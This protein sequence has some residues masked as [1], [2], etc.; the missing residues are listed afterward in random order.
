[1]RKIIGSLILVFCLSSCNS[2][3]RF[4]VMSDMSVDA[5]A[6][7]QVITC[8]DNETNE[9]LVYRSTFN[10]NNLLGVKTLEIIDLETKNSR[11]YYDRND[12][13]FGKAMY[14]FELMIEADKKKKKD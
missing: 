3:D 9:L 6:R 1:M 5:E 12:T 2:G 11:V 14:D 10:V 8:L 4:E 7:F 13:G